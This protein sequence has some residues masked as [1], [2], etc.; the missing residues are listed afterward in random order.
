M[1]RMEA[2][3][4]RAAFE[5]GNEQ[6]VIPWADRAIARLD[7]MGESPDLAQTL[8]FF[9]NYHRRR[10]RLEAAE[11]LLR[12]AIEIAS[13]SGAQV[14]QG[15][16]CLSLG[17]LLLHQGSVREGMALVEEGWA[18][19]EEAGDLALTLR[20]SNTL[21]S[22]MMDYAPDYE[23]GWAVMWKAIELCQRSG[24]RDSEGW[25]WQNVGNCPGE[26]RDRRGVG[27]CARVDRGLLL[28][29]ACVVSPRRPRNGQA[30][31]AQVDRVRVVEAGDPGGSLLPFAGG[32]DRDSSR[33]VLGDRAHR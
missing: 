8:E 19:A 23:R 5:S 16:A 22:A 7:A 18:I 30:R 32:R 26:H 29:G 27:V 20:A 6:S 2:A 11:P 15:L 25:L 17:I 24:R 4:A 13:G 3:L 14:I 33:L 21:A 28:P 9:G 31:R 1:G 12:R 10:G